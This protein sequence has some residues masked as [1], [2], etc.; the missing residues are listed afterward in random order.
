MMTNN[1]FQF[2]S[3]TLNDPFDLVNPQMKTSWN[4]KEIISACPTQGIDILDLGSGDEPFPARSKDRLVTVDFDKRSGATHICDFTKDWIFGE[5]QFDFIYASHVIEH[6]YP[7][8]R[9]KLICNLHSSL[10]ENGYLFIRVPH[11]SSIQGTGWEHYTSYG[12]N[13]V[14]SLCHGRNPNLPV[15]ELISTGVYMGHVSSFAEDRTPSQRIAEWI[16][17]KSFRLT[18]T[19]LCYVVGGIPE[20]Q[21]LLRRLPAE[22]EKKYL[23]LLTRSA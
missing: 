9:D 8:D 1:E 22:L 12:T 14:T 7:Q 15:F 18:D 21:F 3:K 5:R 4:L 17:N 13:G 23:N 19:I 2:P 11:W 10:R 6:L 16:L 20:V